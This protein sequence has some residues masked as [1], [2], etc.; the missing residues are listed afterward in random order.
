MIFNSASG[1]FWGQTNPFAPKKGASEQPPL[2]KSSLACRARESEKVQTTGY[3]G[4]RS[5]QIKHTG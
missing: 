3:Q 1:E 4:K 5:V 2:S